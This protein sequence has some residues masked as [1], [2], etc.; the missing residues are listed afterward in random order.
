MGLAVEPTP[1]TWK[2][3]KGKEWS[4]GDIDFTV[5]LHRQKGGN[6][7]SVYLTKEHLAAAILGSSRQFEAVAI[8]NYVAKRIVLDPGTGQILIRLKRERKRK[9]EE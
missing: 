1:R 7:A 5:K 4:V 3:R 8:E 6:G 9:T 2:R